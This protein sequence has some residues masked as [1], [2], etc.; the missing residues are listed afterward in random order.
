MDNKDF[1]I[2][3]KLG[4]MCPGVDFVLM[5]FR[6]PYGGISNALKGYGL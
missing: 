1:K 4:K 6:L 5:D 3:E 2:Y